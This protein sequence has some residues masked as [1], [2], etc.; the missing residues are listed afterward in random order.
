MEA[1]A[2]E[3]AEMAAADLVEEALAEGGEKQCY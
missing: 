2:K 3:G 1:V